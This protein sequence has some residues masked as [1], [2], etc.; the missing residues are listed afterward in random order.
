[1]DVK[2]LEMAYMY[3]YPSTTVYTVL[4]H[5]LKHLS[6]HGFTDPYSVP[7]QTIE[8]VVADQ[9]PCTLPTQDIQKRWIWNGHQVHVHVHVLAVCYLLDSILY[10]KCTC[11][12]TVWHCSQVALSC[13][14]MSWIHVGNSKASYNVHVKFQ[15]K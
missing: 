12:Y 13:H 2:Q 9:A 14:V 11:K 10:A 7:S 5:S 3:M 6:V 4:S 1:M 15:L 8:R